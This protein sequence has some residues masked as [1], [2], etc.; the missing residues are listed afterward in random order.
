MA[1]RLRPLAL[2]A[3]ALLFFAG[4]SQ[5]A[6]PGHDDESSGGGP[7]SSELAEGTCWTDARLGSDPQEVLKLS[8][9]HSV[10]Y[11]TAARALADRPSF[12][13]RV[14]CSDEHAVE[15]YKVVRLPKL[16]KE[17]T[18][19]AA[20]LRI[21]TPLYDKVA[22][23]IAQA[24]MTEPLLKA[25]QIADLPSAV[26]T[27]MLP[28][29]ATL[30]WAPASPVQWS[31]GQR[32]FACTLTWKDP[33]DIRYRAVF[34]KSFPTGKRTCIETR[35]LIFVDCARKHDR[36]RIAVIEARE[37]VASGDFPGPKAIRKGPTGRYLTV[38]DAAYRKLDAAC[39][40][41]LRAIST[42]KKLTGIANVDV[43]EWP[44]PGGSYPIYCEADTKPDQDSL[45]TEGSVYDKS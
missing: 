7:G 22:R 21:Q 28:S 31:K 35:A 20:V 25:A 39:T 5:G 40:S 45:I 15:A 42:T 37:A 9:A 4:C 29:G 11:L 34:T 27:P 13:R 6:L 17:L 38:S 10:P 19:Y 44:A 23:S 1:S 16:D 24:C 33:E 36:E 8:T 26:V 18:D 43:D 30:G 12:T 32:V 2:L 14:S 3:T 41:Y